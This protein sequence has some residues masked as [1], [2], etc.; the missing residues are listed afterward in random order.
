MKV[1]G[2]SLIGDN[3]QVKGYLLSGPARAPL[4]VSYLTL[5]IAMLEIAFKSAGCTADGYEPANATHPTVP[6]MDASGELVN[7]G[8]KTA[9][10][11]SRPDSILSNIGVCASLINIFMIPLSGAIVDY[12]TIRRQVAIGSLGL[13]WLANAWQSFLSMH[14]WTIMAVL[15]AV[16]ASPSYMLHMSTMSAYSTEVIMDLKDL[17]LLQGAMR[18]FDMAPMLL[19]LIGESLLRASISKIASPRGDAP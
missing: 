5:S 16:I 14:N 9:F 1:F 13:M 18:V 3:P 12:S 4:F 6:L 15:Q 17:S 8:R 2:W 7:C 10:L 19:F 11:N